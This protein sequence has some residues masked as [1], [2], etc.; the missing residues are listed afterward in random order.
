MASCFACWT[1]GGLPEE[2]IE[3]LMDLHQGA[4]LGH[5]LKPGHVLLVG[6]GLAV[7]LVTGFQMSRCARRHPLA[8]S[9][10]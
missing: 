4:W 2:R 6:S 7:L 10:I 5:A 3:W 1:A 8:S 9:T